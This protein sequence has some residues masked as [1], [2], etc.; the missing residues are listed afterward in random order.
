MLN[1][2]VINSSANTSNF[3]TGILWDLSDGGTE[4][5]GAQD[6]VFVS[7]LNPGAIGSRGTYDFEIAVPA[8]LRNYNATGSTVA[9]YVELK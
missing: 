7:E 3:K 9:F 8:Y 6:V 1:I 4:Y 2:P 5:D